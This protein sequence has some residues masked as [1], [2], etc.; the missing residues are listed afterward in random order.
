MVV[1]ESFQTQLDELRDMLVE[2]GNLAETALDDAIDSLKNQDVDKALRIIENDHRINELEEEIN[3][4]A[5]LLIAKQAPVASDLRR[6]IVAIK[7]SSDVERIADFAVNISKSVIR[8]GKEPLIKELVDI[9]ELAE[10]AKTMLGEAIKA[11][12]DED[13]VLAKKMADRDDYVDEKYGELIQELLGTMKE[14]PDSTNQ[15]IQLSFICRYIER[16]ADH[17]TN[18][19]ENIV[20]LVKGK[21]YDLNE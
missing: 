1:R 3:D 14:N 8:I 11:Y 21:H 19:G 15:I 6:I 10:I 12:N 2:L 13:I 20:Y 4:K 7:I 18:I 16:A 5:I 9:P 17:A